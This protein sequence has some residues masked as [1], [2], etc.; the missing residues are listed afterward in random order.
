MQSN[1]SFLRDI[2]IFSELSDGVLEKNAELGLIIEAPRGT[3][4]MVQGSDSSH[5]HVLLDGAVAL[6][7]AAG[8]QPEAVVEVLEGADVL[9]IPPA[10]TQT[11]SLVTAK[12]LKKTRLFSI[13][14]EVWRALLRDEPDVASAMLASLARQWRLMV[15]QVADLKL[16]ST[17]QRLGCHLLA[18]ANQQNSWEV[19]L[20]HDKK[21]LARRLGATPEHLSR[22]FAALR[23]HG[24]ETAGSRVLIKDVSRLSAFSGPDPAV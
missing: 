4:L 1:H 2:A 23:D 19:Q 13:P 17:A 11:P 8:D 12:T 16:R 20:E 22:A 14:A 15:R 9:G 5:V 6:L 21:L 7:M 18:L 3:I 24:V 10:I